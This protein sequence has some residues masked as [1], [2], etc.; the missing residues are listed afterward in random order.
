VKCSKRGNI[1]LARHWIWGEG[2][3]KKKKKRGGEV[4]GGGGGGRGNC[5]ASFC[6]AERGRRG[7]GGGKER[8]GRTIRKGLKGKGHSGRDSPAR[9][10]K[11]KPKGGKKKFSF[12]LQF[13]DGWK[14]GKKRRPGGGRFVAFSFV[15]P[16]CVRRGGRGGGGGK[17]L[18]G[19]KKRHGP[20]SC[21]FSQT[22][23]G[24]KKRKE[25]KGEKIKRR[26]LKKPFF[27]PLVHLDNEERGGENLPTGKKRE[28][29]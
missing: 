10:G 15:H 29:P 5:F 9:K 21:T 13:N 18:E 28:R 16:V 27:G 14:R 6:A 8:K 7:D 1:L 25:K 11:K 23:R 12:R 19:R 22:H 3:E 4:E 17:D 20:G 26:L 2:G 24:G